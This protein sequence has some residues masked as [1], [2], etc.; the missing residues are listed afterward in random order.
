[1][2]IGIVGCGNI[3]GIYLENLLRTA[4]VEVVACADL[5]AERARE[6]AARYGIPVAC[7]VEELLGSP[8]VDLVL[9]LT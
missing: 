1:M 9:N 3:S 2:R 6:K 8:D 7:D 4:G 5:E